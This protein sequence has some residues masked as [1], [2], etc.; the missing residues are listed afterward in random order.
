VKKTILIIAAV[1]SIGLFSSQVFACYWDGYWSSPAAGPVA[2]AYGNAYQEFYDQTSQLRQDFAAKQG[3]YNALLATSKPDSKRASEL[4]R[5]IAVLHDQLRA[6]ARSYNMPA[7]GAGNG[8]PGGYG[9]MGGY[10]CNW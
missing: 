1:T 7:L 3:E 9:R 8:P 4:N 6:Q 10:W 2:G 5:E